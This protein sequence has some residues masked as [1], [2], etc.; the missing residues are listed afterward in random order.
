MAPDVAWCVREGS[1]NP[2]LRYSVRSVK[3][4]LPHRQAWIFGYCPIWLRGPRMRRVPVAQEPMTTRT[5]RGNAWRNLA[6]MAGHPDLSDDFVY[7]EDDYF[8]M[9]HTFRMPVLH[10]GP[11]A[12]RAE[13]YQRGWPDSG[14]T[15]L[16][17]ITLDA[18]K[19][20]GIAD[21]LSYDLH[22]PM[23][24]DKSELAGVMRSLA[25]IPAND[26]PLWR[27]VYGNRLRIGGERTC[28]VKVYRDQPEPDT[29]RFASTSDGT[30][31][32]WGQLHVAPRF[33]TPC[34]YE[35]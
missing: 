13:R 7:C 4:N 27:T 9:A 33:P 11:L 23:P 35:G 12:E 17:W 15:R 20:E 5:R 18:L 10:G 1:R 29:S 31:R 34:R 2:E 28:D 26:R 19:A 30:W 22:V 6:A 32:T 21:P 24:L 8:V 16:L 3:A 25:D 14:Y